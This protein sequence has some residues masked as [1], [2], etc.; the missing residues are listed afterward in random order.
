MARQP[1]HSDDIAI[2]QKRPIV[3][4]A[5]YD[6][7]IVL[8]EKIGNADWLDE[9]A[10]MAEPVTI[11]LE[12]SS[13]P[14]APT[15]LPVWVNG[16]RAEVF[17]NGRWDEIGYLPVSRVLTIRRSVLE[18]ICRAKIDTINTDIRD[19]AGDN[20]ENRIRRNTSSVRSFS[21]IEDCNPRGAAWLTEMIRRNV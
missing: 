16:K 11:R 2:E 3:D 18:V 12:A 20:P 17:Q 7:D 5:S 10:F 13:D 1:L 15:S 4:P 21:V 8:G 14:N 9:L 19:K 6:G